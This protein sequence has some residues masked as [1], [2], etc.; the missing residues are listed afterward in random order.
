MCASPHNAE[1]PEPDL[2]VP[3]VLLRDFSP[4]DDIPVVQEILL[5]YA[6]SLGVDLEFQGFDQELADLPGDYAAPSGALLLAWCGNLLAG[7]VALRRIPD[8]NYVNAAE[9]KRLY[10]RPAFRRLGLGRLLSDAI[11]DRAR[12]LGYSCVLLDTL[13]DME[14]ARALYE[15][16][17]F[18]EIPPYYH[19]PIAGSHYLKVD[20]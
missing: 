8:V 11:L 19:N 14:A 1:C 20:L 18:E 4:R 7:C 15:E 12:E 5:E 10:V 6:E 9:M 16:L 3:A 13:D 2:D 17:G